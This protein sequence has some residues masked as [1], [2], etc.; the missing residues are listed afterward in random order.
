M[1]LV[2]IGGDAAGMSCA[3]KL[4]RLNKDIEIKVFEK[5]DVVSYS[6]CGIPYYIGGDFDNWKDMIVRTPEEFG[7]SNI[8]V[9][10]NHEVVKVNGDEK[11][12]LIKD[13][14]NRRLLHERY[15]I[16]LI[17]VGANPIRPQVP[18]VELKNIYNVKTIDDGR[19]I[20]N[21]VETMS[22]DEVVLIGGGYINMEIVEAMYKQQRKVTIIE[23]G[24]H[25][26]N[27]FDDEICELIEK[28]LAEKNIIIKLEEEVIGFQ[29]NDKVEMVITDKGKYKTE[30]VVL[31]I[32]FSPATD[33]LKDSGIN[34]AENGAVIID[35]YMKTNIDNIYAAGDC[36]QVYHKV[37]KKNSYVPLGTNANKQGKTLSDII[38]G[39]KRKIQ[40]ILGTTVVKI[41]DLQVGKTGL[42]EKEAK[43][44]NIEYGVSFI[45]SKTGPDYYHK[46]EDIYVKI[47][48]NQKSRTIIGGQIAGKREAGIRI[49]V[50]AAAIYNNMTVDEL[51]MLDLCYAPPFSNVWDPINLAGK[52]AK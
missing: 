34:M 28:H 16:L 6:A 48:Y 4:R 50:I 9:F 14:N 22:S 39:D 17:A 49:D 42:T 38:N 19:K 32:G 21:M 37:L 45:K 15:D 11:D 3:S 44:N 31:G 36:A 7:K 13:L 5:T 27:S 18:D 2:I 35:R 8:Q 40:G 24:K 29:G 41:I 20:R 1:K 12:I 23:R 43:E 25:L 10:L 51:G 26:L 30:L 47:I 33:F 52:R 46:S